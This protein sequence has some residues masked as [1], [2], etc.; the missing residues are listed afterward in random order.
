[1]LHL[2]LLVTFLSIITLTLELNG[3]ET[4]A[5][6]LKQTAE[7][8]GSEKW[9]STEARDGILLGSLK[10]EGWIGRRLRSDSGHIHRRFDG[11]K[12]GT[13]QHA[14][15]IDA[16]VGKDVR[17]GQ[18]QLLTWLSSRQS[19]ILAVDARSRKQNVGDISYVDL[20]IKQEG[21]PGAP[22]A[23]APII[24]Y[25][26]SRGNIAVRITN[27]HPRSQPDVDIL[28]IAKEIDKSI[29]ER[30]VLEE[31]KPPETPTIQKFSANPQRVKAG[32]PVLLE[33]EIED[34]ADGTPEIRFRVGGPGQGY[35]ER[36]NDGKLRLFTTKKGRIAL[37]LEVTGSNGTFESSSRQIEV[38]PRNQVESRRK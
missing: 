30:P 11:E 37:T 3:Q 14:I 5:D 22:P 28:A 18:L 33:V 1:M 32:E 8:Y 16:Y 12:P 31:G 9:E 19:R 25:Y 26:F 20:A 24:T 38:L 17:Q 7:L 27:V 2:R 15:V 6:R 29:K 13:E 35:V 4:F 34:P 21:Q 36:R 23:S 10:L